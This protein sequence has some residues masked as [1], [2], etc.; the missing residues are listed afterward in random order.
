M[1]P[2]QLLAH[3]G[4]IAKSRNRETQPADLRRA[5]SA[6]YY[7]IFHLLIQDAAARFTSRPELRPL[8]ARK[9]DHGPMRQAS[10]QYA[11]KK[12]TKPV[13]GHLPASFSELVGE[14]PHDLKTVAEV[15]QQLYDNR[16]RADYDSRAGADFNRVAALG[17]VNQAVVA[18][19]AWARV[20][21]TSAAEAYLLA[22][23]LRD[24]GR[25]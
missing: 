16:Q 11:G 3:A 8:L 22:M 24:S 21:D 15:F 1:N 7:A 5:V 19:Q 18:F 6:A 2:H 12:Q 10:I 23:L 9:F 17:W 4:R 14:P 20:R 13:E 25:G